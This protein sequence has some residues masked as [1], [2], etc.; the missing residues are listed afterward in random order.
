MEG[1][2][3]EV[4][5]YM[6]GDRDA[7]EI[8]VELAARVEIALNEVKDILRE[9]DAY[10]LLYSEV[11]QPVVVDNLGELAQL[12]F[13]LSV[14]G[15]EVVAALRQVAPTD[16]VGEQV[17]VLIDDA[18]PYLTGVVDGFVTEVSLVDNKRQARRVLAELLDRKLT[19]AIDGIDKCATIREA[20][21]ALSSLSGG[22][23]SCVPSNTSAADLKR[24]LDLDLEEQIEASV[25]GLIPDII[26]FGDAQLRDALVQAGAGDNL[27]RLDDVREILR[28]GWSYTDADL[29]ERLGDQGD[30]TVERLEDLRSFLSDGWTYT[31]TRFRKDLAG[32][33]AGGGESNLDT[34]RDSMKTADNYKL[35]VYAPLLVLLVMIAF[36]GG[37]TWTGRVAYAAGF[38]VVSAAVIFV[39]FGPGYDALAKSGPV[40]EAVGI[41]DFDELRQEALDDIAAGGGEF[42][43]TARLAANKAFDIAESISDNFASGVATSS[44]VIAVIGLIALGAAFF[45]GQLVELFVQIR[46]KTST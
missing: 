34:F 13:G 6:I 45:W 12:P 1:A 39:I 21:A 46:R 18:S 22:L 33:P 30:F 29:K 19:E 11:V 28:D 42:P 26:R 36:L 44:L 10:E 41:S 31:E 40:Y 24:R 23:P 8:R 2:L 37:R 38:L 9:T 7:F 4:T 17:E 43:G 16:W 3:D 15:E 14:T 25:L 35:V 20:R 5:P 32:D 27:V